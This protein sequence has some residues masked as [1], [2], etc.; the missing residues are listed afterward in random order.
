MEALSYRVR[1]APSLRS[2]G[3]RGDSFGLAAPE[4]LA[5]GL[6]WRVRLGSCSQSL[7]FIGDVK[8][9]A[10]NAKHSVLPSLQ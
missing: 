3:R 1:A 10:T 2:R 9:G 7:G 4:V 6:V 5:S 8:F